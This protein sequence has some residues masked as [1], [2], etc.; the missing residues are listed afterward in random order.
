MFWLLD[1][2]SREDE[3]SAADQVEGEVRVCRR[4]Y[5]KHE[6][7]GFALRPQ[8]L[9]DFRRAR[10]A[11]TTFLILAFAL[12]ATINTTACAPKR[13]TVS[14]PA[15]MRGIER[16]TFRRCHVIETREGESSC[17]CRVPA[18]NWIR[19]LKQQQWIGVCAPED[20]ASSD[21][22]QELSKRMAAP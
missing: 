4:C 3:P 10:R 14:R 11:A 1:R 15:A 5:A 13:P 16:I 22:K 6:R 12:V 7:S 21:K 19:D 2:D 9:L 20:G 17:S 18:G 8:R